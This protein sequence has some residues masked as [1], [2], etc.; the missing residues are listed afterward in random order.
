MITQIEHKSIAGTVG[1]LLKEQP[2]LIY[3]I[4]QGI[5]NLSAVAKKLKPEVEKRMG[6]GVK[7]EAIKAALRRQSLPSVLN[8]EKVLSVLKKSRLT[9]RNNVAVLVVSHSAYQKVLQF[10]R[11]LETGDYMNV[12]QETSGVAVIIDENRLAEAEK[13]IDRNSILHKK[14]GLAA[15]VIVGPG[16]MM[17]STL[18]VTAYTLSLVS[19]NGINIEEL[20]SC[21]SDTT[22]VV[23]RDDALKAF[24]IIEKVMG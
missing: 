18:G 22:I 4:G 15:I 24:E 6:K 17:R 21:Y 23:K 11:G 8:I 3:S 10:Q 12:V 9:L 5:A 16:K 7:T 2:L 14:T 20:F 19:Y 13:I 1:E